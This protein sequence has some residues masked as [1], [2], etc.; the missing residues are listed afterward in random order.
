MWFHSKTDSIIKQQYW[1]CYIPF[2]LLGFQCPRGLA[3]FLGEFP[4]ISKYF[5]EFVEIPFLEDVYISTKMRN[6]EVIAG[7]QDDD[8]DNGVIFGHPSYKPSARETLST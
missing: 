5:S 7:I 3:E 6:N 4:R 1:F 8:R 2:D